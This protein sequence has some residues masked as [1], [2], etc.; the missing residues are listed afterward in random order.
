MFAEFTV[1]AV[2]AMF[3]VFAVFAL[4]LMFVVFA[5]FALCG[6]CRTQTFGDTLRHATRPIRFSTAGLL[7]PPMLVN[8]C[9]SLTPRS[10]TVVFG[11]GTRQC[12]RMHTRLANGV[13][14]NG[15]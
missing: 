2:F 11:L 6:V 7:V 14:R 5:V 8:V 4:F 15:Q 10:M 3:A 12:V 13:L 9:T 1:F